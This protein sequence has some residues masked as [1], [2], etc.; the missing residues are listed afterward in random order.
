[1][2]TEPQAE[3]PALARPLASY[4]ACSP[5]AV[6]SGSKAQMMYFVEDAKADIAKLAATIATLRRE[7]DE[8]IARAEAAE[9]ELLENARGRVAEL[10][11]GHCPERPKPGG[12][13]VPEMVCDYPRCDR[14]KITEQGNG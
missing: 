12:C 5:D 10:T 13:K 3:G 8:A 2:T 1:M 14:R 4:A 11:Y 7:R 6:A 9:A